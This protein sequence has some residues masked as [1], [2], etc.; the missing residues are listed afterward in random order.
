MTDNIVTHDSTEG[1]A[2]NIRVVYKFL[3]PN[4]LSES[5]LAKKAEKHNFFQTIYNHYKERQELSE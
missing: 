3:Y 4:G 2:E 5:T 1:L